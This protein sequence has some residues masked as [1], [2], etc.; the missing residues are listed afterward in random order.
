MPDDIKTYV[1]L[2]DHFNSRICQ[3]ERS[4]ASTAIQLEKRLDSMNEFRAQLKDQATTLMP[5][6]EM[7]IHF[8]SIDKDIREL[9][10][11]KANLEGKASQ[12]S[13]M[14]AFII[15]GLSLLLSL[16]GIAIKFLGK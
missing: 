1:T 4:I 3:I 6:S 12:T 16:A 13:V 11:S 14:I 2:E 15:S 5:R 7:D 10:E 9:R 8:Q